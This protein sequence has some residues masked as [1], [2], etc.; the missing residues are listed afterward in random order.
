[1]LK[2]PMLIESYDVTNIAHAQETYVK[3][4]PGIRGHDS[5]LHVVTDLP[6]NPGAPEFN[7]KKLHVLNLKIGKIIAKEGFGAAQ[8]HFKR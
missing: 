4:D 6:I 1:M 7:A 2:K 8:W 5:V 3:L